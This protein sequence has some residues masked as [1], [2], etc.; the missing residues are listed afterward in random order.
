M[1]YFTD[2]DGSLHFFV[3]DLPTPNAY[4]IIWVEGNEF[5]ERN[6]LF[7]W[8]PLG[9][10]I[11]GTY[12]VQT[13][14]VCRNSNNGNLHAV[15]YEG[16]KMVACSDALTLVDAQRVASGS[17]IPGVLDNRSDMMLA[18]GKVQRWEDV[19]DAYKADAERARI[20]APSGTAPKHF[21]DKATDK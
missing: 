6:P 10:A 18:W 8:R 20:G 5:Y 9:T 1:S 2:A 16:D 17:V 3:G 19:N 4:Q 14:R 11:E 15:T 13:I 21:L 7:K 12:T